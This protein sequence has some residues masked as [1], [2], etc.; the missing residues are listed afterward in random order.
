MAMKPKVINE[1]L[2]NDNLYKNDIRYQMNL[3]LNFDSIID[4]ENAHRDLTD[5]FES[6]LK[7]ALPIL[8]FNKV[9]F[10]F[11]SFPIIIPSVISI[12]MFF[13]CLA[14]LWI[15][16]CRESNNNPNNKYT[17]L[18][19]FIEVIELINIIFKYD[20]SNEF[21]LLNLTVLTMPYF[22]VNFGL[23]HS[24][25][26][27]FYITSIHFSLYLSMT[28]CPKM[29]FIIRFWKNIFSQK[30]LSCL[31]S[32]SIEFLLQYYIRKSI[33]EVW[34]LYDSFKRS[35]FTFKKCL[36]D[37]F[38]YPVIIFL[39]KNN[40]QIFYKNSRADNFIQK[41]KRIKTANNDIN[42]N[43]KNVS[44][45]KSSTPTYARRILQ[46]GGSARK[47]ENLEEIFFDKENQIMFETELDKCISNKKKY[48]DFPMRISNEKG[49]NLNYHRSSKNVTFFEGDIDNFDWYRIVVSTCFWKNQEAIYIQM[50]KNDDYH[51]NDIIINYMSKVSNELKNVTENIDKVCDRILESELPDNKKDKPSITS[52]I[53]LSSLVIPRQKTSGKSNSSP[54]RSEFK[55]GSFNRQNTIQKSQ[56]PAPNSINTTQVVVP[57][58][59]FSIWFFLKYNITFIYELFLTLKTYDT[60][61]NKR[62]LTYNYKIVLPEFFNYLEDYLKIP[63]QLKNVKFLF[64]NNSIEDELVVCFQYFRVIVFNILLFIL[65]NTYSETQE[66]I[67]EVIFR[68]EKEF[69]GEDYKIKFAIKYKD[70]NIKINYNDVSK[71]L[72]TEQNKG[73]INCKVDAA[74]IKLLDLGLVTAYYIL[75]HVFDNDLVMTSENSQHSISFFMIGKYQ[76]NNGG[77][78]YPNMKFIKP[79][80]RISEQYYLKILKKIYEYTPPAAEQVFVSLQ[81]DSQ[82]SLESKLSFNVKKPSFTKLKD[83]L[84]GEVESDN[85]NDRLQPEDINMTLVDDR[86]MVNKV[87]I[88]LSKHFENYDKL[89]FIKKLPIDNIVPILKEKNL[90]LNSLCLN[91]FS[92]SRKVRFEE[93]GG[94]NVKYFYPPRFLIVED[95]AFG[96]INLIDILKKQKLDYLID[97]SAYG[98][99]SVQKFK[100]FLNKG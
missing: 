13:S 52:N 70:E 10:S 69:T 24:L 77:E 67:I 17:M 47:E 12:G 45:G 79:N 33:R 54:A 32:L 40:R 26:N 82:Y 8:Y 30:I 37:D 65:N 83:E 100:F 99:E 56:V 97:I 19:I 44:L 60:I 63:C 4:E 35:Y 55:K 75:N 49:F 14:L 81:K 34:A 7:Y 92:E 5:R 84:I 76:R 21:S 48:F 64:I 89:L 25:N 2:P 9:L 16:M 31:V 22:F 91:L 72:A 80:T 23:D 20:N 53:N 38:P 1:R 39:K 78:N 93:G 42:T 94:S 3:D 41:V 29:H 71:I 73:C 36:Y 74:K 6:F 59:D 95:N 46:K 58:C 57:K 15:P 50:I 62:L 87:N 68:S 51:G 28:G 27:Y 86:D 88:Q 18:S 98:W 96:R 43:K 66:R 90:K 85:S 11:S 61:I